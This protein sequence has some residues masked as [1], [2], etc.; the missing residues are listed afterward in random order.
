MRKTD[1]TRTRPTTW[2]THNHVAALAWSGTSTGRGLWLWETRKRPN[3]SNPQWR[4]WGE[5]STRC[6]SSFPMPLSDLDEG[7]LVGS[8][9]VPVI[10]FP[11]LFSR[12]SVLKNPVSLS[13]KKCFRVL[14]D[15]SA[16]KKTNGQD[17]LDQANIFHF[18]SKVDSAWEHGWRQG[19]WWW[20][21]LLSSLFRQL[22][23]HW[24]FPA[25]PSSHWQKWLSY[26][27]EADRKETW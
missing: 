16:V 17:E 14:K 6:S 12:F 27:A 3:L 10:I 5:C 24:H 26:S 18:L 20:K 21:Q 19:W 15:C 2:V 23:Y 22:T 11:M 7:W 13:L 9:T 1:R 4:S 8:F 25:L